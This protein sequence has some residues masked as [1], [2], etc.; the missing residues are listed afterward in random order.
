M[1]YILLREK[2]MEINKC[3]CFKIHI[4]PS[5]IEYDYENN[6][7]NL[8]KIYIDPNCELVYGHCDLHNPDINCT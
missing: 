5:F 3:N 7:L 8:L 2:Q 1:F 6:S 4:S